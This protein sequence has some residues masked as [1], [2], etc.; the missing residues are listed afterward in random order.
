MEQSANLMT[1]WLF[2]YKNNYIINLNWN[3][4]LGTRGRPD[5]LKLTV[6]T[7]EVQER[8]V[9]NC[10]TVNVSLHFGSMEKTEK[11]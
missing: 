7:S 1:A 2:D 3:F 4:G 5:S 6:S 11:V 9:S 8:I 10:Y